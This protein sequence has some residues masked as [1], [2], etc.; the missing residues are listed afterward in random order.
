MLPQIFAQLDDKAPVI[1]TEGQNER[2][3][4]MLPNYD[5][6]QFLS[7]FKPPWT[8]VLGGKSLSYSP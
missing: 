8:G 2:V 3:S 1:E 5:A 6:L 7:G 4:L